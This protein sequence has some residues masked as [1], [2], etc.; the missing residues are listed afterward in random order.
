MVLLINELGES[1]LI[2]SHEHS[3]NGAIVATASQNESS[4][5]KMVN[6]LNNMVLKEW[7]LTVSD[8]K[9]FDAT[10]VELK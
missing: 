3:R 6:Y 1:M 4:L 9:P 7:K 5:K 10:I 8:E 2:D